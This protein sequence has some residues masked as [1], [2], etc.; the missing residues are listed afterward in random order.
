MS[1][2]Y[3]P[4]GK[5]KNV[6]KKLPEEKYIQLCRSITCGHTYIYIY[7]VIYLYICMPRRD[8]LDIR[9]MLLS[10]RHFAATE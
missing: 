9:R 2:Q 7:S 4:G 6:V 5:E 8:S 10:L 1:W 3:C